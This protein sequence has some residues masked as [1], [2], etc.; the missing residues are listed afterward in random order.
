[1]SHHQ[2][3][4]RWKHSTHHQSTTGLYM[5]KTILVTKILL[6]FVFTT[7]ICDAETLHGRV[8]DTR[9]GKLG[10]H[11]LVVLN[12]TP[13]RTTYTDV[14]GFYYFKNLEPG[15]YLVR[16]YKNTNLDNY[17]LKQSNN[18]KSG[19]WARGVRDRSRSTRSSSSLS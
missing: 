15:A 13:A 5:D 17:F 12:T 18:M 6:I 14:E 2:N 7:S 3:R 1:M 11:M 10:S 16:L 8:Y 19:I 4:M 9:A